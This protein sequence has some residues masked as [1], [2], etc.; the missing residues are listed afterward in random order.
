MAPVVPVPPGG[1]SHKKRLR[2]KKQKR[3][4]VPPQNNEVIVELTSPVPV[5][6]L[7]QVMSEMEQAGFDIIE[8]E[9]ED[10]VLVLTFMLKTLQ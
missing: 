6:T 5:A 2:L 7:Q 9:D 10:D 1:T 4:D 3:F 8:T